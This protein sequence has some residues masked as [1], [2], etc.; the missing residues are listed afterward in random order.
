M[1]RTWVSKKQALLHD[2]SSA[3][4][5]KALK[6][7]LGRIQFHIL[8]QCFLSHSGCSSNSF[9]PLATP[10]SCIT[11]ARQL[12]HLCGNPDQETGTPSS[13]FIIS[14]LLYFTHHFFPPGRRVP[15]VLHHSI[16]HA[17]TMGASS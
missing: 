9:L 15:R 5:G 11:K 1:H 4:P 10:L 13:P 6:E 7:L 12:G 17:L 3:I 16:R 8:Q 14:P 2:P